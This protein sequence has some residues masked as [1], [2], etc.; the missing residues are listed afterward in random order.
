MTKVS[1]SSLLLASGAFSWGTYRFPKHAVLFHTSVTFPLLSL[2]PRMLFPYSF[3]WKTL[4]ISQVHVPTSPSSSLQV[5]SPLL[6]TSF[7]TLPLP[8]LKESG[9][10]SPLYTH[11]NYNTYHMTLHYPHT[12]L[13]YSYPC[14]L[15]PRLWVP[16]SWGLQLYLPLAYCLVHSTFSKLGVRNKILARQYPD[17]F[18]ASR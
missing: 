1:V 9:F 5:Y 15:F 8:L 4:P 7:T 12:V 6:L 11:I 10:E 18:W 2:H 3:T 16:Y 13:N 17:T 14:L